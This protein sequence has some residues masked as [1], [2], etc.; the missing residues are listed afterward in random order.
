M[1]FVEKQALLNF[2]Y[3]KALRRRTAGLN[4]S[5]M[6]RGLLAEGPDK[7]GSLERTGV[8]TKIRWDQKTLQMPLYSL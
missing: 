4:A 3:A 7:L 2:V 5:N 1:P 8:S 6:A